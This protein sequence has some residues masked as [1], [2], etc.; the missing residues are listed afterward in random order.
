[1]SLYDMIGAEL[2]PSSM[3]NH[4]IPG[5]M[6][7]F[8][9]LRYYASGSFYAVLGDSMGIHKST[10]SRIV[11]R[12]TMALCR[13]SSRF[14]K[15][16]T[17]RVEIVA[18][19]QKFYEI[20]GFPNIIGAID[21][22]LISILKP[23]QRE[24]LY[25][26]RKGGHSLNV[27]ATCNSDLVFT[28]VVA[29]YPGSSNDSYIWSNCNLRDSF[30]TGRFGNGCLL[31]DSGFA[32]SQH[33]LTPVL[34]PTTDAEERYNI[35]H[36]RT[37]QVIERCFGLAKMRFRCIHKSCGQLMFDPEKCC[38]II[39]AC[40]VLHNMCVQNHLPPDDD[41]DDEEYD[42]E[43]DLA[44]VVPEGDDHHANVARR[45]YAEGNIVRRRLIQQRF[46]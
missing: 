27:L 32:L 22:T 17:E 8:C 39:I 5:M 11:G 3:R 37:R 40:C 38:R 16:P 44:Y 4:A 15:F 34:N 35:T 10:V 31:G 21:G 7:I 30:E 23:T 9:A 19:K 12:V 45:A 43:E 20:A 26:S 29:K 25:V 33:L 14:I 36:K 41:I 28:N 46:T 42:H 1:M 6:Q 24:N 2:E 13:L 18:T